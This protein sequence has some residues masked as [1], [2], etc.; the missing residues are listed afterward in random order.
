MD[1]RWSRPTLPE[2]LSGARYAR[3]SAARVNGH[4][5]N[6]RSPPQSAQQPQVWPWRAFLASCALPGLLCILRRVVGLRCALRF[7]MILDG[8]SASTQ[9]SSHGRAASSLP[10]NLA[11]PLEPAPLPLHP[12]SRVCA[13]RLADLN[14]LRRR[15]GGCQG[16]AAE[17]AIQLS[18]KQVQDQPVAEIREKR[19]SVRC[20][21]RCRTDSSRR[22]GSRTSSGVACSHAPM[23]GV[24]RTTSSSGRADLALLCTAISGR[25]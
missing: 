8:P 16:N 17:A 15:A 5:S 14:R 23:A 6:R 18:A 22:E 1:R 4:F 19:R 13:H 25:G 9:R 11:H 7:G 12:L 21:T 2:T 20:R 24:V 10:T 3:H